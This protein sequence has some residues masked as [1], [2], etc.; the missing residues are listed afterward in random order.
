MY[1]STYFLYKWLLNHLSNAFMRRIKKIRVKNGKKLE[2]KENVTT[3]FIPK[4]KNELWN[5]T[6]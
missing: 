2:K 5:H 1:N 4:K 6:K 3:F